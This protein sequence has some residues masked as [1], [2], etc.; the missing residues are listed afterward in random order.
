MKDENV[1]VSCTKVTTNLKKIL[2]INYLK[3]A[4]SDLRMLEL[5][6]KANFQLAN[7]TR[8]Y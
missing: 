5:Q 1:H 7:K 8:L 2:E 3:A 6:V 4:Q